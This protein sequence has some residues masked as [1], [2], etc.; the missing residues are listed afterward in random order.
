[1][2]QQESSLERRSKNLVAIFGALTAALALS[3]GV[4]GACAN[5]AGN[6]RDSARTRV[7]QL[8]SERNHLRESNE[9][10]ERQVDTLTE[11]AA[12]LS[13]DNAEL[14]SENNDLKSQLGEVGSEND[15]TADVIHRRYTIPLRSDPYEYAGLGLDEGYVDHDYGGDIHYH[16]NEH[17]GRPEFFSD[18]ENYSAQLPASLVAAPTTVIR[19]DCETAVDLN[20][21]VRPVKRVTKGTLICVRSEGGM[22]LLRVVAPPNGQGDVRVEQTYWPD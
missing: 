6:D 21:T 7:A 20:P 12:G 9:S 1:M 8:E 18:D 5:N 4:L 19:E 15:P 11:R 2:S 16:R 17:T 10:L 22:S 13:R 3:T 14:Q